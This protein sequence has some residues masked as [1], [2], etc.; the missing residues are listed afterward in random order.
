MFD[1]P[2]L[3]RIVARNR[4]HL[5]GLDLADCFGEQ[6]QL[7]RLGGKQFADLMRFQLVRQSIETC[8]GRDFWRGNRC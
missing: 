4:A 1:A 7:D 2:G 3:F 8:S 6:V 5:I